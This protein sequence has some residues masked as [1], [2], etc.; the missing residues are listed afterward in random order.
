MLDQIYKLRKPDHMLRISVSPAVLV[1]V[2]LYVQERGEL[3]PGME[4]TLL[5]NHQENP[6]PANFDL[7]FLQ[8]GRDLRALV[9]EHTFE[10]HSDA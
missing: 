1:M 7:G 5:H 10:L 4:A 6:N 8:P 2:V 3:L 9:V